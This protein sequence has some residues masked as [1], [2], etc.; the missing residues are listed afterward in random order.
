M[1]K[2]KKGKSCANMKD[3]ASVRLSRGNHG[4]RGWLLVCLSPLK[5]M[6]QNTT[7]WAAYK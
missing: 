3:R 6:Y 7:D 1:E 2:N 5:L 4:V